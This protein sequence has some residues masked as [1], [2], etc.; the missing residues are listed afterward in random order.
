MFRYDYRL[1]FD[2]AQGDSSFITN[3]RVSTT[4][5]PLSINTE[6]GKMSHPTLREFWMMGV[7]CLPQAGMLD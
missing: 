2:Y 1:P 3:I 4:L 7:A 6:K 5:D